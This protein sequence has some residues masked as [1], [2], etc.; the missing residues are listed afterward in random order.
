VNQHVDVPRWK[1]RLLHKEGVNIIIISVHLRLLV[2]HYLGERVH[3]SPPLRRLPGEGH[4]RAVV[5]DPH[6]S[7]TIMIQ[8]QEEENENIIII[9]LLIIIIQIHL[10]LRVDNII[11]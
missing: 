10:V 3:V 8:E 9:K 7:F 6:P 2:I 5:V 11:S 4:Y 1:H